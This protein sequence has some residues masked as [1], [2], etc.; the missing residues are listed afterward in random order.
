MFLKFIIGG[1]GSGKTTVCIDEIMA[2]LDAEPNAQVIYIIPEQFSLES[3][4]NLLSRGRSAVSRA[5]VLSFKRLA[6]WVFSREGGVNN[7][8]LD[9]VGKMMLLQKAIIGISEKLEL[10]RASSKQVGFLELLAN[11]ISECHQNGITPDNLVERADALNPS[12]PSERLLRTKLNELAL[13]F[14]AYN[15]LKASRFITDDDSLDYLSARIGD[16]AF[17]RGVHIWVDGFNGFTPQ[18]LKVLEALMPVSASMTIALTLPQSAA[19]LANLYGDPFWEARHALDTLTQFAREH[20]VE[21]GKTLTLPENTKAPAPI[22]HIRETFFDIQTHAYSGNAPQIKLFEAVNRYEEVERAAETIMIMARDEG[23]S[24]SEIGIVSADPSGYA[25]LV[26]NIFARYGIPAFVDTNTDISTHPVADFL[27]AA[28]M[29]AREGAE[30]RHVFRLLRT[31]LSGIDVTDIDLLENYVLA[32]GIRGSGW[33]H[34]WTFGF[35]GG[36]EDFEYER[37]NG[38]REKVC[39]ILDKINETLKGAE[40]VRAF[41][42][43]VYRLMTRFELDKGLSAI[44]DRAFNSGDYA[45]YLAHN[46]IW[47]KIINILERAV[48]LLGDVTVTLTQFSELFDA[49]LLATRMGAL[50]PTLDTVIAGDLRR[51]R[52][53]GVRALFVLGAVQGLF[54]PDSDSAGLLSDDERATAK[55]TEPIDPTEQQISN[56]Q[57][58][59]YMSIAKPTERLFI[60]YYLGNLDGGTAYPAAAVFTLRAMFPSLRVE[61]AE[62]RGQISAAAPTFSRMVNFLGEADNLAAE[63]KAVAGLFGCFNAIEPYKTRLQTIKK[64]VF[65][66]DKTAASLPP[67]I[68][69]QM[70]RSDTLPVSASRLELYA[71]CPFSYFAGYNLGA[72]ERKLYEVAAVD[73]GS[74]FHDIMNRFAENLRMESRV[75]QDLS[76]EDINTLADRSIAEALN[77]PEQAIFDSTGQYKFIARRIAEIARASIAALTKQIQAGE[78]GLLSA[79]IA[80]GR[81]SGAELVLSGEGVTVSASGRIDR[82][83]VLERDGRRYVK[84]ID[85]KS[86]DKQFS[87][88]E[89]LNGLQLQLVLYMDAALRFVSDEQTETVPAAMLYFHVFEPILHMSDLNGKAPEPD[90]LEA[91]YLQKYKMSGAVLRDADVLTALE[92][93]MFTRSK[94]SSIYPSSTKTAKTKKSEPA[95]YD[96]GGFGNMLT[97]E[98]FQKTIAFA[99]K[100]ALQLAARMKRG[101]IP[102]TPSKHKARTACMFCPYSPICMFDPLVDQYHIVRETE[103]EARQKIFEE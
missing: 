24:F 91:A 33:K 8:A 67:D 32:Y 78:F 88:A 49:G 57:L 87:Y 15:E 77:A 41:S 69:A 66:N 58:L 60:S 40:D 9:D 92:S 34:E 3:E 74:V 81:G 46:Q 47:G 29:I 96:F 68:L 93:D 97:P 56:Q 6:Y 100:T 62:T 94:S 21:I 75:W 53:R 45:S 79:E 30:Y 76:D 44:I 28:L 11:Q 70:Y 22:K 86:G 14:S 64:Y 26:K 52:L 50:P 25:P 61:S 31:G 73:I 13:I 10:Y 83:D 55:M 39:E 16:C 71:G 23:Y 98:Q 20:G 37:L 80:F 43:R 89:L 72:N 17:L 63:S 7:T 1:V 36:Y 102:I 103:A 12:L 65:E 82:V 18:E 99:E 59:V 4:R 5:Q 54:P 95:A 2:R 90:V 101:E 48:D 35:G 27:R 19:H 85:Y 51:S 42:E 38:L 84:I